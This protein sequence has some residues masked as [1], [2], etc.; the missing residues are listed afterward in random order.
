MGE[1]DDIKVLSLPGRNI[2]VEGNR[3]FLPLLFVTGREFSLF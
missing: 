2:V 1:N 3:E